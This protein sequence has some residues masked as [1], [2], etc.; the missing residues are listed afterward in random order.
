[1]QFVNFLKNLIDFSLISTSGAFGVLFVNQ[2]WNSFW[3]CNLM[4]ATWHK[5]NVSVETDF[6]FTKGE[7]FQQTN[8]EFCSWI[9]GIMVKYSLHI[10]YI[11]MR[12]SCHE[13]TVYCSKRW[14]LRSE[15]C[16]LCSW[17]IRCGAHSK[18]QSCILILRDFPRSLISKISLLE[19]K[20]WIYIFCISNWNSSK[21]EW[22]MGMEMVMGTYG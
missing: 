14:T 4:F 2:L 15:H 9:D 18:L 19:C 11:Y 8:L 6:W 21:L 1:M 7:I 10:S 16:F 13:N 12:F 20:I 22:G 17:S 5:L 3:H